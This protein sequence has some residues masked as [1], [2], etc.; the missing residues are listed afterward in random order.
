MLSRAHSLGKGMEG[1]LGAKFRVS[2]V[3]GTGWRKLPERSGW[4]EVGAHTARLGWSLFPGAV[5]AHRK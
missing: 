5:G 2:G 4:A 3:E 1:G